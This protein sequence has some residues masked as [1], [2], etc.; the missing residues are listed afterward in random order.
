[1]ANIFVMPMANRPLNVR[2]QSKDCKDQIKG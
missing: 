1:M 2:M